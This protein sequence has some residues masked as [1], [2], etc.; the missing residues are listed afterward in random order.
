MTLKDFLGP[1]LPDVPFLSEQH[2]P[3]SLPMSPPCLDGHEQVPRSKGKALS[4]V[5]IVERSQ[6][7]M[8]HFIHEKC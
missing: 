8:A 7:M 2:T 4:I 5:G 6:C 1:L 3:A